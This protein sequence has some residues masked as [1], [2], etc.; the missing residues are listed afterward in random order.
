MPTLEEIA[1]IAG[2][3]RSTVSR[4]INNSPNVNP[5]TRA[6]VQKVIQQLNFHPNKAARSLAGGHSKVL[7]LVFPAEISRLFSDPYFSILIQG[8]TTTCN[9]HDYSVMLWLAEPEYE[10][11]LIG[12]ILQNGLIDGLIVSSFIMKDPLVQTLTTSALP[13]ILVGRSPF[14]HK[15]S[16]IDVDNLKSASLAVNYLISNGRKRI[17]HISGPRNTFVG[18]DRINGYRKALMSHK[19]PIVNHLILEGDFSEVSGYLAT[20]KILPLQPD[21]IFA[22]SDAMAL[23]ALRAIQEEGFAVPDD[24]A[25]IG[26]DDTPIAAHAIPP[27]T[28]VRQPI[29]DMGATA[30]RILIA[31][32]EKQSPVPQQI[33]LPTQLVIRS[34]A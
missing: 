15:V 32:I 2:V 29:Y 23:G 33:I 18:I 4:V 31:Q 16:F 25:V 30:A 28:T 19:L 9:E 34:S 8:V 21:A 10:P 20:R 24:V 17:A 11:R 27:L 3:S 14:D 22:A 26:F 13:Y 7:G 12:Q 5:H 1:H 6:Q